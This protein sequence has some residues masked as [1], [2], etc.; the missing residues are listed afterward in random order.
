MY[1]NSKDSSKLIKEY[2]LNADI[3]FKNYTEFLKK[4]INDFKDLKII[5]NIHPFEG[6]EHYKCCKRL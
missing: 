3:I 5:L 2:L 4:I 6:K 1:Y